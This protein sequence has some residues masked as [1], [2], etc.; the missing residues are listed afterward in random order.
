MPSPK[1]CCWYP[2]CAEGCAKYG[3]I[4]SLINAGGWG[5]TAMGWL[6]VPCGRQQSGCL[7]ST[8]ACLWTSPC[9]L[10]TLTKSWCW[11]RSCVGL[12]PERLAPYGTHLAARPCTHSAA[13][14]ELNLHLNSI[15]QRLMLALQL[16]PIQKAKATDKRLVRAPQHLAVHNHTGAAGV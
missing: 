7:T 2:C 3:M 16:I 8:P 11:H 9:W 14:D 10:T 12:E 13:A 15:S 1:P 6:E 4:R 5:Y